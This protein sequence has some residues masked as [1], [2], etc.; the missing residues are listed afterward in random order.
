MKN[1][2]NCSYSPSSSHSVR[3]SSLYRPPLPDGMTDL[4]ARE[5]HLLRL[6]DFVRTGLVADRV[7][8]TPTKLASLLGISKQ[9]AWE[10][11]GRWEEFSCVDPSGCITVEMFERTYAANDVHRQVLDREAV[12]RKQ[13]LD[14]TWTPRR[15]RCGRRLS[16]AVEYVK[17]VVER[18]DEAVARPP[19]EMVTRE[20]L[21]ALRA[22]AL[23]LSG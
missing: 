5:P 1:S 19:V 7:T 9:A 3:Y 14:G 12:C 6:L 18:A 16:L 2:K 22:L 8:W 17:D 20:D 13:A 15:V 10:A 11:M 4:G 21:Q 23:G